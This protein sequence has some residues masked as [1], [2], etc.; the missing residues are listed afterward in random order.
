VR[1]NFEVVWSVSC[2]RRDRIVFSIQLLFGMFFEVFSSKGRSYNKMN[3]AQ[4]SRQII[5]ELLGVVR[6]IHLLENV[7]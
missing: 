1:T 2:C 7:T 5:V 6:S 4:V 3:L